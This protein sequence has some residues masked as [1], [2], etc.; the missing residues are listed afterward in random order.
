[1]FRTF[2]E[3]QQLCQMSAYTLPQDLNRNSPQIKLMLEW[4]QGIKEKNVS[5]LEKCLHK[6]FRRTIY[7][8]NI[9]EPTQN[10]D[11]FLKQF[12][13]VYLVP[14]IEVCSTPFY[15]PLFPLTGSPL[16]WTIHSITEAPGKVVLHVCIPT[17]SEMAP[18]V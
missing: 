18:P 12:T 6:D 16:Q 10:R 5:T 15:L 1:M 17:L 9:G 2:C 11:E 14:D 4:V 8:K 7:P 13:T 3:D